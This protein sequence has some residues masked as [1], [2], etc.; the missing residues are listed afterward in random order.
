MYGCKEYDLYAH[1]MM[2]DNQCND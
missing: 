1:S 2:I